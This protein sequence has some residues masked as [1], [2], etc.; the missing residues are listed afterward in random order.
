MSGSI[1]ETGY[2]LDV[3]ACDCDTRIHLSTGSAGNSVL[4]VK[5]TKIADSHVHQTGNDC[6][7]DHKSVGFN[8]PQEM[9]NEWT[10]KSDVG[11]AV[12]LFPVFVCRACIIPGALEGREQWVYI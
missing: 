3:E 4:I 9:F 7:Q 10:D 6:T 5:L 8:S 11:V 1:I 2:A 12:Q